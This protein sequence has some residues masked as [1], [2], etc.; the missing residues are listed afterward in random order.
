MLQ[1]TI[2]ATF[3]VA[4]PEIRMALNGISGIVISIFVMVTA[5]LLIVRSF[6]DD[7]PKPST[8]EQHQSQQTSK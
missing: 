1:T 4:S 3:G 2:L 8:Q 7:N 6:N 5:T